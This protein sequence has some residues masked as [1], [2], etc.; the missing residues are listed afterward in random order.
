MYED[1]AFE[2]YFGKLKPKSLG[3]LINLLEKKRGSRLTHILI[4]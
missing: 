1:L 4:F 3:N 2:I